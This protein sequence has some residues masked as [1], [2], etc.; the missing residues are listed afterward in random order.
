[1]VRIKG[2]IDMLNNSFKLGIINA[3]LREAFELRFCDDMNI[4]DLVVMEKIAKLKISNDFVGIDG[5]NFVYIGEY[6][7]AGFV[8]KFL[9]GEE[10]FG[11]IFVDSEFIL[12]L[13]NS[14]LFSKKFIVE[15]KFSSYNEDYEDDCEELMCVES[16]KVSREFNSYYDDA[17]REIIKMIG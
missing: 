4:G 8:N 6:D 13:K 3:L 16:F 12:T 11:M 17:S 7:E 2:N 10:P 15:S 14:K 1:M 9:D 5:I